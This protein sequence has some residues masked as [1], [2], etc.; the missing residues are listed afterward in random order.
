PDD[1]T[2]TAFGHADWAR[3]YLAVT[4]ACVMMRRETF[5]A[6]QGYD[7][8]FIVCGSD[9]DICLRMV[10]RGMRVVYTPYTCLIHHESAT[11][12]TDSIPENDFWR[13]FVSY[14]PWLRNGDPFYNANLS[15]QRADGSLREDER[16]GEELA[17]R[18]LATELPGSRA[19]TT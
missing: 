13:S 9:V 6:L 17:V 15:L 7:E 12:K 16:G 14:R 5:D 3:N 4:S 8:R 10:K 11:R 1:S 18:V 19:S 2:Q